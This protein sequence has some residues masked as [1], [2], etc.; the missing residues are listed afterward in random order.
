[1]VGC[2][3]VSIVLYD[4]YSVG[5]QCVD[6]Q[7][8]VVDVNVVDSIEIS[9]ESDIDFDGYLLLYVLIFEVYF[10]YFVFIYQG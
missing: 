7:D 9:D 2:F 8:V 3:V 5:V 4:D 6:L 10:F 1:M